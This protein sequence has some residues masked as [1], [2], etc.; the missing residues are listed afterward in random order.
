MD[1]DLGVTLGA[2]LGKE[3]PLLPNLVHPQAW[4][5]L[6]LKREISTRGDFDPQG[7]LAMS[8]GIFDCHSW[9]CSWHLVVG[10]QGCCEMS[11]RAQDSPPTPTPKNSPAQMSVV[12]RLQHPGLQGSG[13]IHGSP[14][15]PLQ[16]E[17][18]AP[19][20]PPR[21]VFLA[22]PPR[23]PSILHQAAG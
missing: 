6:P 13:S 15:S 9:E 7:H 18:K 4:S 2:S 22:L 8:G 10:G 21:M 20:S 11:F 17:V 1:R 14:S 23:P 19:L 5:A 12:P 3:L 16:H